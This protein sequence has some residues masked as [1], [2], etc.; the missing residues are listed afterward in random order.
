MSELF[1]DL[2]PSPARTSA[3][4][5][6][7]LATEAAAEAEV[8]HESEPAALRELAATEAA[9]M[10]EQQAQEEAQRRRSITQASITRFVSPRAVPSRCI[11]AGWEANIRAL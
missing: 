10:A 2:K 8:A 7:L 9:A 5:R 4:M 6:E 3:A 11:S 1:G